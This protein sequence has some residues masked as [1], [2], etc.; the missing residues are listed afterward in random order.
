VK[1][2]RI[3]VGITGGIAAY[4]SAELVRL[5]VKQG[6][7]V[8]VAMTRNAGQFVTP[9]TFE[10]LSRNRVVWD[11]FEKETAPL[12]HIIWG[13]EAD[14]VIIAPATANFIGKMANG[15][16]D[17]FLSTMMIASTARVLI[18]PSMNDRM[19]AHP[20][21]QENIRRLADR[22]VIVMEPSEGELACNA[23]GKGRLPDPNEIAEQAHILLTSQDLSGLKIVVTSGPTIEPIDPVR[24]I[25]NRSTGRMGYAVAR[26]AAR[27]GA[28]V[29]LV[30]GPTALPSPVGVTLYR[31]H[32]AMDMH[33]VIMNH[34]EGADAIIKAAAVSDYRPRERAMQKIK[35]GADTMTLDLEKTPDILAELGHHPGPFNPILVGFAAETED[36]LA[37][38]KEKLEKKNVDM[39]VAND[40]SRED[41][42][43]ATETNL[44]KILYRDGTQEDLPL[45]TKDNV[46]H[47]LLDRIKI[48]LGAR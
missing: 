7:H 25:S 1:D 10:A 22:G 27:R 17:D 40:V 45:M 29:V 4:K 47:H 14:L 20:A 30:S 35:K 36:L 19:F 32:T 18:C 16:A 24:F 39:I 31:V 12:D 23:E 6:A 2:K 43:F 5:L 42:G 46:A 41:A 11:M 44:V 3:I 21:V 48:L 9:L 8:Q 34:R 33:E 26:A 38:A 28:D 13:Q 37:H 15:I